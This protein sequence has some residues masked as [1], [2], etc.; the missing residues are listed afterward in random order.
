MGK[1]NRRPAVYVPRVGTE[2]TW[3]KRRVR[4]VEVVQ[5]VS[6]YAVISVRITN[7]ESV[8]IAYRAGLHSTV[9]S[10]PSELEKFL[11]EAQNAKG[12]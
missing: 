5:D 2:I 8:K 6:T 1:R 11:K 4:I 7:L 3:R 9:I 12:I 10:T